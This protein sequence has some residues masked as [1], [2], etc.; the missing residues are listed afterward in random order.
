MVICIYKGDIIPFSITIIR[1]TVSKNCFE[2]FRPNVQTFAKE[3][4]DQKC[5]KGRNNSI[6]CSD[7]SVPCFSKPIL[8]STGQM[9]NLV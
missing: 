5:G 9:F 6:S 2:I 7:N 3:V 8:K 1:Y 4:F